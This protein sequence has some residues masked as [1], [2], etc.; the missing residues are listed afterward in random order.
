M[1]LEKKPKKRLIGYAR[2]STQQQDLT[3]QTKALKRLGCAVVYADKASGS[4]APGPIAMTSPS[5][6]FSLTVFLRLRDGGV[7]G[8]CGPHRIVTAAYPRRPVGTRNWQSHG[9]APQP[10]CRFVG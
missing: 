7:S 1:S 5:C 8:A 6:G 10:L 4:R 9:T 3:R 2:V